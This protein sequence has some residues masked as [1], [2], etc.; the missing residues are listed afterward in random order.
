MFESSGIVPFQPTLLPSFPRSSV[1]GSGLT[2]GRIALERAAKHHPRLPLCPG[3]CRGQASGSRVQS[4]G[5]RVQG[6][7]SRVQGPGFR[8]QGPGSMV[9]GPGSRV[10]GSGVRIQ[11]AG[12]RVQSRPSAAASALACVGSRVQD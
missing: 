11:S 2:V 5:S 9:Q 12:S 10:Q 4:S 1:R 8:V 3:L 6:S 7:G